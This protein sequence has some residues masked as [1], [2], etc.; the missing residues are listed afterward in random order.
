VKN[1]EG[2]AREDAVGEIRKKISTRSFEVL[3]R[4]GG[5]GD[6]GENTRIPVVEI[7]LG[8]RRFGGGG[9]RGE[10][11]RIPVEVLPCVL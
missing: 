2:K 5:G 4:F 9:D 11:T 6:R 10:N 7:S 1:L 3:K 8:F